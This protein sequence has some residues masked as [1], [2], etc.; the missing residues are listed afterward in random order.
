M[1][2]TNIQDVE[3]WHAAA[4][5]AWISHGILHIKGLPI[6]KTYRIYTLSGTLIHQA[7]A[8][9]DVETWHAASPQSGTYIIHSDIGVA[10]I[11]W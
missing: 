1:I 9:T 10:K 8:T 4:I 3:T 7:I 11:V 5:Q 6:G 2:P